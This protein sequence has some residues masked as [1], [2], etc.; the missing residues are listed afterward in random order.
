MDV[1]DA[2]PP[3]IRRASREALKLQAALDDMLGDLRIEDDNDYDDVSSDDAAPPPIS[4]S[5]SASLRTATP[6]RTPK[7]PDIPPPTPPLKSPFRARAEPD[8]GYVCYFGYAPCSLEPGK[9]CLRWI[10]IAIGSAPLKIL[11]LD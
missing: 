9:D 11:N 3:P 8:P 10:N 7:R 5:R 1:D 6:P 2:L 4:R